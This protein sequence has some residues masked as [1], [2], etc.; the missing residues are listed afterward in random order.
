METKKKTKYNPIL[1]FLKISIRA[2]VI[3]S[4]N[5]YDAASKPSLVNE[6]MPQGNSLTVG[7]L[8]APLRASKKI[9]RSMSFA[10]L[11]NSKQAA[12]KLTLDTNFGNNNYYTRDSDSDETPTS[13]PATGSSRSFPRSLLKKQST[14]VSESDIKTLHDLAKA[15][16]V[17]TRED[18][19]EFNKKYYSKE[20]GERNETLLK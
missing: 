12:E 8:L 14:K 7:V 4:K 13:S 19:I 10:S 15:R 6:M 11:H 9:C 1:N 16:K 2:M 5:K 20:Q 17:I 3:M 18:L